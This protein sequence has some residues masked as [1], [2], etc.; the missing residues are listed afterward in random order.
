ARQVDF[1]QDV[2]PILRAT[3]YS[4]HGAEMQEGGL[5]LD[6]KKRAFQG[7]DHGA[8]VVPGKSGESLLLLAVA[9]LNE[10]IGRMP[11]EG[12]GTPL[13]AEQIGLLRAWIEQDADW[14]ESADNQLVASSHWAFQPIAR[15]AIPMLD[16]MDWVRN[17][18]DAFVL[19]RLR[20][21]MIQ[22]SPEAS[23]SARLRRA[24]LDLIGLP[25]TIDEVNAFLA[26]DR[27]D[28]YERVVDRL[29]E[30]EHY[31]ERWARHW[32]DLAR[33]ADSDGYEKDRQRP[34]AWRYREW[35]INALNRDMPFDQFTVEQIA[36]DMLPEASLE[37]RVAAG[38]HRNTL[39]NTEGG[40]DQ[41]EDRVK[42]T[43]DRTNTVGTT[44]L[45]LTVGCA[46]CHSH[47]YDPI[48]QRDYYSLYAF[49][50]YMAESDI[51]APTT[52]EQ[53]AFEA[54][55]TKYDAAHKPF[56]DAIA[57]YERE[58]LPAAQSAWE[59]ASA[60]NAQA[61][62]TLQPTKLASRHNAKLEQQKDGA[63]L[64]S[65]KN[66][67]SD[68]Y[69]IEAPLTLPRVTAIRLEVLPD[70]SLPQQG[71]G[72]AEN[73][74]FVLTNFAVQVIAADGSEP[75]TL[76]IGA[77][78]A[79]FSQAQWDVALAINDN[80]EDGWAVSPEIGKR[81]VAAFSLTEPIEAATDKR[82]VVT[83]DQTY[84][85]EQPHNLGRFRLSVTDTTGELDL[86]GMPGDVAAAL[87]VAVADRSAEQAKAVTNYFRGIDPEL[88]KLKSAADEHA[89]Q[90]PQP[91][92]TKA[93]S[94]SQQS[95]AA[96]ETR[97]FPRGDFLRKKEGALVEAAVLPFLPDLQL[98]GDKPDRLDLAS[99]LVSADNPLTPRVT[100]NRIWQRYFG[101]GLVATSDDFGT[102][103]DRPSHPEL[104]DWL[105]SE[106]VD[107]GWSLKHIHRLIATSATYQQ[108][109]AA[110]P[111]LID[112]DPENV[113][114]ARYSRRRVEAELI[115]D[116]ALAASGLLS[117]KVGG[118]SVRPPQ[119]AEYAKLTYANSA[120][121]ETSKGDDRYRRGLYTFFQRTS[122][123]PM[124]MT[125]DSPD[126]TECTARRTVSN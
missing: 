4:C 79:D 13:T 9:G 78:K 97:V 66:M 110:R 88:G 39:H 102:Q 115:R 61:W 69:T 94:I 40:T 63:I 106:F 84:N 96:R 48:T 86:E 70:K 35:V 111:D 46:Q 85:R 123:Y 50:N 104:L 58:Q 26:D 15:P 22:P 53:L 49:F 37:Q 118:P 116:V 87:Q 6:N 1:V 7:G 108:S 120:K 3:C 117:R 67:L 99:W 73:G 52:H 65:G 124:L 36:G 59:Q 80:P 113:L 77:S 24:Y 90:A 74:N 10:D 64:A 55:K 27:D 19:D 21:E 82:I 57:A 56:L 75:Q 41:E 109:S 126:S 17:P 122:P 16:E 14:P 32:L 89:K 95:F 72:R 93:Q 20:N 18:I 12:E 121:W 107:S 71:P 5:R 31:G 47:K 45:G 11:P 38:F 44:W 28:A 25:P 125:F 92:A 54:A 23:K 2:Q 119:P 101:R 30:S 42:K 29:L 100:V 76:T 103:G 43:I 105:A 83:L 112:I 60:K 34:F 68:V 114:L 33:Y 51:P 91:P 8:A 62:T 98:R 81:H